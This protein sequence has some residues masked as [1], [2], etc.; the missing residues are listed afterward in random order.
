M[1]KTTLSKLFI[2]KRTGSKNFEDAY[3]RM[4]KELMKSKEV[5]ELMK[6]TDTVYLTDIENLYDSFMAAFERQCK[7]GIQD[8]CKTL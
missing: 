5:K 8:K 2:Q 4:K 1:S 6:C 3:Q 7:D